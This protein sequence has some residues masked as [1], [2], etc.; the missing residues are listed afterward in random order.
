MEICPPQ[1]ERSE[2]VIAVLQDKIRTSLVRA[3]HSERH[4]IA[5]KLRKDW[6][7][8]LVAVRAIV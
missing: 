8:K 2:E 4:I 6:L 1:F 7:Q 3:Q 5:K